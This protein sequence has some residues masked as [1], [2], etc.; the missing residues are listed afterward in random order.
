MSSW[1]KGAKL[2]K[3]INNEGGFAA[4]AAAGLPFLLYEGLDVC[5]VPPQIDAVRRA[6]VC[7]VTPRAKGDF[8]VRFEGVETREQASKLLGCFCLLRKED[9]G[10]AYA[11]CVS[12][13]LE[14]W[15]LFDSASDCW[16]TVRSCVEN[17]A[18]LLLETELDDGRVVLVPFVDAFLVERDAERRELRMCLPDGLFDL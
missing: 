2:T 3:V 16:G 17:P 12:E 18:Q 14:G 1:V 11:S 9:A 10:D 5:F 8:F 6:R 4:R 13:A 15:R 7:E